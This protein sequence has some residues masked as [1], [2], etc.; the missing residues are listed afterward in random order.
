MSRTVG[1]KLN[2]MEMDAGEKRKACSR[3]S[4]QQDYRNGRTNSPAF[5]KNYFP[6][7]R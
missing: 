4:E 6:L 1:S 3:M 2:L 5:Q 7:F